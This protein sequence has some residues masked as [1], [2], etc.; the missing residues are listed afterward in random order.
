MGL[1]SLGLWAL[2]PG[3]TDARR[4]FIDW[5]KGLRAGRPQASSD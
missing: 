2:D 4:E 5:K 1:P 3:E